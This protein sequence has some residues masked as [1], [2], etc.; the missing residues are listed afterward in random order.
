MYISGVS[1][2]GKFSTLREAEP[3]Q[4]E[5]GKD[6]GY[7]LENLE[8]KFVY[9]LCSDKYKLNKAAVDAAIERYGLENVRFDSEG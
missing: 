2:L 9:N 6:L 5:L 4:H 7:W 8:K 3:R 1:Q